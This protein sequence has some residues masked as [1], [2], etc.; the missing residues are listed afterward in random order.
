MKS[1]SLLLIVSTSIAC[2][3]RQAYQVNED[4]AIRPTDVETGGSA[5]GG[6]SQGPWGDQRVG[7]DPVGCPSFPH[8]S[9]TGVH[10]QPW[11]IDSSVDFWRVARVGS[12]IAVLSNSANSAFER[13]LQYFDA[14]TGVELT[15]QLI[16]VEGYQLEDMAAHDEELIF[17]ATQ[18]E[19]K[20]K[21]RVIL[22][23]KESTLYHKYDLFDAGASLAVTSH[24]T[25]YVFESTNGL[26]INSTLFQATDLDRQHLSP[27]AHEELRILASDMTA[28][29][30]TIYLYSTGYSS[31]TDERQSQLFF[32]GQLGG[33]WCQMN[34][35]GILPKLGR[36]RIVGLDD[37]IWVIAE[38]GE[39]HRFL[40]Q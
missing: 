25:T 23:L 11:L 9:K 24:P 36:L 21:T 17:T 39:L 22:G 37:E 40:V 34:L 35:D 15:R 33:R 16:N 12:K 6:A 13:V 14:N 18:L 20:I 7:V 3:S 32:F 27:N 26:D 1:L 28:I 2:I 29:G 4:D 19:G 10:F 5:D 38:D 8:Y 30:Q 31:W